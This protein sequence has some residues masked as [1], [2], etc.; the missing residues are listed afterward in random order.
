MV[1]FLLQRPIAVILTFSLLLIGGFLSMQKVP[2]SLLPTIDIPQIVIKIAYPNTAAAALEENI[3]KP[4]RENL[5]TLNKLTNIESRSANHAATI[6]LTFDYGTRMDFAY[7]D[8]NE[9]LDRIINGLPKDLPRPQ[10]IRINTSDI[11]IVRIQVIPK[12]E[13]DYLQ[14]S[15]LTEK[16]IKKRLEEIDGISLVDINGKRSGFI[17]ITPDRQSLWALGLDETAIAKAIQAANIQLGDLSIKNG[18]YQF[19]VKLISDLQTPEQIVSVP[20]KL[21]NNV[22]VPLGQL[23]KVSLDTEKPLGFHYFNGKEGLII[24]VHKQS[25]SK[26]NELMPKIDSAIS[27]F[28]HDYPSVSF[29]KTQDQT[30]LLDSGI[31]NLQQDLVY[32]GILCVA[33]LF[34]FL[35]NYASP[36]L[37]SISI[38]I[39]LLMTFIFFYAFNIS[40]NIISLSGLALG[41][42]MLIDNSIVVLDN[43]TRKRRMGYSMEESCITGTNEVIV[44]IISQVLTTVAIYA[45][46]IYLNGMA[47]ALVYDQAVSLTISLAVSLLV[48]FCLTPVLYKLFLKATPEQLKEDT[49][50]YTWILNGYHKMIDNIFRRK[51]LYFLATLLIMP[52]GFFLFNFI[53][54]TAL[55]HITETESLLKIDWNQPVGIQENRMR[56]L[57]LSGILKNNAVWESDIGITQYLLQQENNNIQ[58]AEIYYKCGS[59]DTKAALDLKL[60]SWLKQHY[61]SSTWKI[62]S[63]PNAFTQLFGNN[64][65]FIEVRMRSLNEQ[66]VGNNLASLQKFLHKI[67]YPH[68]EKGLNFVEEAN[69]EM[70]LDNHKMLLYGISKDDIEANLQRLFG[71]YNVAEIKRFGDVKILRI[72]SPEKDI[73]DKLKS[74][75]AGKDNTLY[76]LNTFISYNYGVEKKYLTSD[77]AGLYESVTFNDDALT[78]VPALQKKLMFLAAKDGLSLSFSGKYYSNQSQIRELVVIFIISFLLLYFILAVQFENL[79]HPFIVMFTIPLGVAGAMFILIL[80]GGKLD[81]MAAIGFIVVLGIIVDDPTLKVETINRLRKELEEQGLTDKREILIKALHGA[82]EICL[83]PLLMVS[84]TTS[85]ALI[86]VLFTGGI[87]NDLQKPMVYVIVGGLTIGTFFTLWFIPLAY[88]F[89]TK[90]GK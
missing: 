21:N 45:P 74:F 76:P 67:P 57:E 22:S 66:S 85:L 1:R 62:E 86:P 77:K 65:P 23:C 72:T 37:M 84:L 70:H 79:V 61:P 78:D 10:V 32:G 73:D 3:T 83:K 44:P 58:S 14:V 19:F 24:T 68:W 42:G 87:G 20:V 50:L 30:Y 59:E 64:E 5:S 43:I 26:M 2:V 56:L 16:V 11:P 80:A 55:P 41:V 89:L 8:V 46:L 39:S 75:I 47:G 71:T 36:I 33:V 28:K 29:N 90:K 35:G 18:Q 48:A 7:I 52:V 49:R 12:N 40:F 54:V 81:V 13:N 60:N 9:K 31:S 25:G 27:Q 17:A 6:N 15:Q 53:K 38:P 82:G 51:R 63:A 4:I 34:M 88:W 69:V